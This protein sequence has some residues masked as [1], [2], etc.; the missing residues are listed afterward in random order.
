MPEWNGKLPGL[1]RRAEVSTKRGWPPLSTMESGEEGQQRPISPKRR[2]RARQR[3]RGQRRTCHAR[4]ALNVRSKSRSVRCQYF[5]I[6]V[7][8]WVGLKNGCCS[9]KGRRLSTI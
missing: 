5:F 3:P 7:R 4:W 2:S 1:S 8:V 9:R 6:V